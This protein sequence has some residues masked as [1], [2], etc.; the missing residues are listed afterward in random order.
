MRSLPIRSRKAVS[1]L[2][3]RA[4]SSP[5][6][7]GDRAESGPVVAVALLRQRAQRL[8]RALPD[9][10][11]RHVDDALEGG[12][13]VV[14]AQDAQVG[15]RVLD[16]AA[17]VE[18]RATD[19]LVAQAVA[20]EGLLDGAALGVGAVHDGHVLE[21]V[22]LVVAVVGPARE[23]RAGTAPP[24][25][26]GLDLAGHPLGLL[27]LAVGLEALDELAARVLGPELL[28]L[29]VL[30]ARDHGVGRVED[31]LGGAVVL[32]ELDHGGVGIVGLEVED[33]A[34]VRA[35]PAVD[36]LVV[37]THDGE[38]AVLCASS[39]THRYWARLV[40]WYS[41]MWR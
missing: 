39:L 16:L 35:A 5:A 36:R 22:L 30:V 7:L 15:Q 40:S 12:H 10:A 33:V 8:E 11:R 19:Q 27:V 34:Q 14:V 18:A 32:L 13:V 6:P 20:Q 25:H 41:S 24:G 31:E 23:D 28:V 3:A 37:V 1:E 4:V 21:A 2:R 26:E 38:V 17:L 29:A 9:A